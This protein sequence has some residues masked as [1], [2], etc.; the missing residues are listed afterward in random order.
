MSELVGNLTI[1][2]IIVIAVA[3]FVA[4]AVFVMFA[5][6][7]TNV[8]QIK[9]SLRKIHEELC[10]RKGQVSVDYLSPKT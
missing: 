10:K 8:A 2:S 7:C 9:K 5:I 4:V 6:L 3:I 1:L